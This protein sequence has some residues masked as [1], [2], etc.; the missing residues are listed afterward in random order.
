MNLMTVFVFNGL[1]KNNYRE[2]KSVNNLKQFVI[3]KN[4]YH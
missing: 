2:K 4:I 3:K 1:K